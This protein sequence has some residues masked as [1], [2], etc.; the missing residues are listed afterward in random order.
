MV[1]RDPILNPAIVPATDDVW[2]V[3]QGIVITEHS[4]VG[5]D[6][7][8]DIFG[9]SFGNRADPAL[10][11][12]VDFQRKLEGEQQLIYWRTPEPVTIGR[13]RLFADGGD[14]TRREF[15]SMSIRA[16]TVGSEVFNA[17]LGEITPRILMNISTRG[18]F[19]T[20]RWR[21]R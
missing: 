3:S 18:L 7:I 14:Q 9:G 16:K 8:R 10:V 4:E 6:D 1:V 12:S 2:D 13:V 20:E 17:A 5:P 19:L 11:G 21:T 15:I